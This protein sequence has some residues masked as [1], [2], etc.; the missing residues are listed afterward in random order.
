MMIFVRNVGEERGLRLLKDWIQERD[1]AE[2]NVLRLPISVP[3][4]IITHAAF[5]ELA[6]NSSQL[7]YRWL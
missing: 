5:D 1:M 4:V 2:L 7:R 6:I 3:A